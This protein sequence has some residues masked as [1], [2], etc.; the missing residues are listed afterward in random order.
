MYLDTNGTTLKFH[1]V[2]RFLCGVR[3]FSRY[4][5]EVLKTLYIQE[6]VFDVICWNVICKVN[7][8]TLHWLFEAQD[9][10]VIAKLL[11]SSEI[12]FYE[13]LRTV[14]PFDCFVLGYFLSHTNC[15][16]KIDI[17]F[18]YIGYEEVEM[19]I[20]G[21]VEEETHC[22][23]GI[24]KIDLHRNGITSEGVKHLLNLPK[25]LTKRLE[26]LVQSETK[27]DSESCVG[28]AHLIPHVPHLKTLDL[29]NNPIGQGGAVHITDS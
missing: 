10:D 8:N 9:S 16:W 22:M 3:K 27:L 19:L 1:M 25:Q 24:S 6:S 26:T 21:A 2:L 13:Q 15:T 29:S 5:S 14:T 17:F 18:C 20:R 11:G 7:F 28:L 12:L 4:L 23:G